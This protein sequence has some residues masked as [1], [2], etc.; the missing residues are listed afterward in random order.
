M[1]KKKGDDSIQP[2]QRLK[3]LKR[4]EEGESI[5]KIAT[6]ANVDH[7]TV[8]KHIGLARSEKELRDERSIVLRNALERHFSDLLTII[9]I[10]L[11]HIDT[12]ETIEFS[13]DDE[14]LQNA[15]REH[16]PRSAIWPLLRNWN[17]YVAGVTL[18]KA[19]IRDKLERAVSSDATLAAI[20]ERKS[21]ELFR[22]MRSALKAEERSHGHPGLDV[23]VVEIEERANQLRVVSS[24]FTAFG[25]L[26]DKEELAVVQAVLAKIQSEMEAW[27]EFTELGDQYRKLADA[28]TKLKEALRI[29]KWKRIV[30]GRC[31]LCPM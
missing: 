31:R 29:L 24:A 3:W 5:F 27:E 9:D 13:G 21:D 10:M 15:L 22:R 11:T 8:R 30:P 6:D 23:K 25:E 28:R 19:R 1:P 7:R 20:N 12:G 17:S 2:E 18:L 16:I 14:F 4:F 26:D